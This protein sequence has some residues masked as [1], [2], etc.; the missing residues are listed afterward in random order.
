M[1]GNDLLRGEKVYL[2][3]STPQNAAVIAEAFNNFDFATLAS[4]D[5]RANTPEA[6]LERMT[7]GRERGDFLFTIHA[8]SND[9]ML[10]ECSLVRVDWKNRNAMLGI[11]ITDSA[12]WGQSYGSEAANILLRFGFYELNL[13]RIELGVFAY[14]ARAIRAYDKIG[15]VE[16]GRERQIL[17]RDGTYHDIIIMSILQREWRA[18]YEKLTDIGDATL[19]E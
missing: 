13:H 9:Q 18:R 10:G 8:R 16:E 15:F 14:N 6:K 1:L 12:Y 17:F 7:R 19:D 5:L 3:T 2:T 11:S 4:F